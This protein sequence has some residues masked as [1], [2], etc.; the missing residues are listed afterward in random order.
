MFLKIFLLIIAGVNVVFVRKIEKTSCGYSSCHPTKDGYINVHIIP[1]SHDDVGW[2]KTIDQYYEDDV[3]NILDSVFH[4]LQKDSDRRFIYVESAFLFKWWKDRPSAVR[5]KFKKLINN[6]QLELIGGAWSMNDEATTHYQSIIDQFTYGLKAIDDAFGSCGRPKVGWQIDS[7]GHS[8]EMASIFSELG[9]DGL[10][11]GRIDYQ[12]KKVRF[13]TKTAEMLWKASNSLGARSEIFTHVLYNVYWPPD[14]L[15]F[16]YYC[17]AERFSDNPRILWEILTKGI[18]NQAR[19][20]KTNN[21]IL[22]MGNDFHYSQAEMWFGNLDTII[23]YGNALQRNG[24]K[25]NLIYST[26]SCYLKAVHES[27]TKLNITWPKKFDDFFPY[28]SK[29]QSYWTGFYTSRP[30]LKRFERIGNNF[31]QVCKQ[32]YVLA[33][34]NNT[35]RTNLATLQEAMGVLQH[36]DAVS[37]TEKQHVADDYAKLLTEGLNNCSTITMESLNILSSTK[38]IKTKN[39]VVPHTSC[40]LKNI[41]Q[42][43]LTEDA[44]NFVVTMYNPLSRVVDHYVRVPVRKGQ[45]TVVSPKG[46]ELQVQLIPIHPYVLNAPGRKSKATLDLVFFATELPPLG[47]KTFYVTKRSKPKLA[48]RTSQSETEQRT[49]VKLSKT[50]GF[51]NKIIINNTTVPIRQEFYYYEG[52][53]YPRTP[54]GAYLFNPAHNTPIK[55]AEKV[56]NKFYIGD[57]VKEIHQT[58]D[59]WVS[60]IIRIYPNENFVELN[61]LIGPLPSRYRGHSTEV[62]SR[63]TTLLNTNATFY[64]DSNG[65]EM[66]KRIINWRPT[67]KLNVTQPIPG[68]YYPVT[69]K[70]LIRDPNKNLEVAVLTDRAQGGASLHN[71]QIELMLH[72]NCLNDDAL[73]VE[74]TLDEYAFGK[75]L[76]VRGSHYLVVGSYSTP[77]NESVASIEKDIA[78]RKLLEAWTFLSKTNYSYTSYKKLYNM[79]YSGLKRALP[80]NVQILTLEPWGNKKILLRLEHIFEKDEDLVLSRPAEINLEDLFAAFKLVDI[81]ETTLGGN[82]WLD[83]NK[84]MDFN[85]GKK[86]NRKHLYKRKNVNS[87]FIIDLDPM[88]I[89]SGM[90]KRASPRRHWDIDLFEFVEISHH[91][92]TSERSQ[93]LEN[94]DRKG[95]VERNVQRKNVNGT[96]RGVDES[97]TTECRSRNW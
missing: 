3:R 34:L 13:E 6:G 87:K 2:V 21:V 32:L 45:Y 64:T 18:D 53:T 44:E 39:N 9:F 68:N 85:V 22:T 66:I 49:F 17:S 80:K 26:P 36:H 4:S 41:S 14:D 5:N 47:F 72:R 35:Y 67:W 95:I 56:K 76:V 75:P 59:D 12:D 77:S 91:D 94:V 83:E 30:A 93:V 10:F 82:Q 60:Q 28:A 31:L 51:L 90:R 89:L 88:Q 50:H 20:Y 11:L 25:Y 63:Y 42:C 74:E 24:S 52:A 58:F 40:F 43:D 96:G 55:V 15:C 7:F 79:E 1:H 86:L 81:R 84:R 37:G 65:R 33:R 38:L 73:G 29:E 62:I 16:D 97:G 78:Q 46:D 27:I 54:S 19:I 61:W 8:K 23:T 48:R 70:I 69:T 71:G 92:G 57:V